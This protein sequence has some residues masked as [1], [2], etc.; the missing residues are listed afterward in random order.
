MLYRVLRNTCFKILKTKKRKERNYLINCQTK[1]TEKKQCLYSNYN[2]TEPL[3]FLWIAFIYTNPMKMYHF[4]HD[5][6][7]ESPASAVPRKVQKY[8]LQAMQGHIWTGRD[9]L[10]DH[11]GRSWSCEVRTH[12]LKLAPPAG[13]WENFTHTRSSQCV[14]HKVF[15]SLS[16]FPSEQCCRL[17]IR[18]LL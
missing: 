8:Y 1:F 13:A 3:I 10:S 4:A 14:Q 15:C 11:T 17:T 18:N 2:E 7:T 5:V 12:A 16:E 9:G 6:F